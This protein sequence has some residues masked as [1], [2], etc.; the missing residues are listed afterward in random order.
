MKKIALF[1]LALLVSFIA[2]SQKT[3]LD[4]QLSISFNNH[5][6]RDAFNEIE[7]VSGISIAYNNGLKSLDSKVSKSFK[8]TSIGEILNELIRK[9]NLGYKLIDDQ[10]AVFE[11]PETTTSKTFEKKASIS[12]IVVEEKNAKPIP[13]VTVGILGTSNGSTTDLKGYFNISDIDPGTYTL[14]FSYIGYETKKIEIEIIGTE[15]RNLGTIKLQEGAISLK[16]VVIT[17]GSFSVMAKA[18]VSK[19]T[20][21]EKDIKNMSFSEDV[22]RAVSRLPGVSS[23]DFSSKFSVRGGEADEVMITL[24]GMDLYDPFHQRDFAGGLF[25]IVDIESIEGIDLL[26][27]GFSAEYGTRQSGV[28]NMRTRQILENERRHSVG[29]S[30]I[31]ARIYSEGSLLNEKGSYII[32][33]RRGMLD[34]TIRVVGNNQEIPIYYDMFGK[35]EYKLNDKHKVSLH[36]LYAGDKTMI[37]DIVL[38]DL[39]QTPLIDLDTISNVRETESDTLTDWDIHDTKYTNLYS[40]ITLTSIYSPKLYSRT[41]FFGGILTYERNGNAYKEGFSDKITFN[42]KDNRDFTFFGVKQDWNWEAGEK[43]FLKTGFDV[44]QLQADYRYNFA[45][46]DYRVNSSGVVNPYSESRKAKLSPSGQQVGAYIS[47]KIMALPKLFI[48]PGLRYDYVSYTNEHMIGPRLSAAYMVNKTTFLRAAWGQYYQPQFINSIQVNF[49]VSDF[50]TA[51]MA[52]HYVLGLEHFFPFGLEFRIEAYYKDITVPTVSYQNLRDPWEVFP[53]ARNDVVKLN[54][55]GARSKGIELF[56]KYDIGKKVSCW[57]TY[58]WARSEENIES[59]EFDGLL[60][61]QTGWLPR[62]N[63]QDHTIFTD[64]NY[65]P[66]DKWVIN[67]SWQFWTGWPYTKYNYEYV[68]LDDGRIHY[69]PDHLKFRGQNFE[70][71]HRMDVRVNRKFELKYGHLNTY[72]HIVNVY[73]RQNPRKYDRDVVSENDELIPDGKGGFITHEDYAAWL[74]IVPNVGISWEF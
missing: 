41:I 35:V 18:T 36:M 48:E 5:T 8:N 42:L 6:L 46:N 13:F 16:E 60:E 11:I 32:S 28:F 52:E 26:T 40:W 74:G 37:R 22:T 47:G 58:T 67:M 12:G 57:F 71:Y 17:P 21:S 59:I 69:Y 44:R 56:F 14:A 10:I 54:L 62:Y 31:N 53:E 20:L 64:I 45:V 49:G 73:N 61:K 19:Q 33:A 63:N 15:D 23:N 51:E 34:Q 65:R 43:I 66:N 55:N 24:D 25:S 2:F 50:A 68:F 4:S 3:I 30:A 9:Q 7:K 72:V 27:G 29:I 70:P 38:N 39:L 1:I